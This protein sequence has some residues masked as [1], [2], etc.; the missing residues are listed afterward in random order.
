MDRQQT[1]CSL[2]KKICMEFYLFIFLKSA[3]SSYDNILLS[4]L[5]QHLST[6]TLSYVIVI[7]LSSP[8][9][10]NRKTICSG[11]FGLLSIVH[12]HTHG[13]RVISLLLPSISLLNIH[14]QAW[15]LSTAE[16]ISRH[17]RNIMTN[18]GARCNWTI[19]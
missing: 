8:L 2:T 9:G 11:V 19:K 17:L 12:T 4:N 7:L 1:A 3:F 10:M 6:T 16:P 13:P 5:T 15:H 18:V 14:L